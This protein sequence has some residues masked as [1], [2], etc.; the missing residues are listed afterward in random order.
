MHACIGYMPSELQLPISHLKKYQLSRHII[1]SG[2]SHWLN[3]SL[4][5]FTIWIYIFEDCKDAL[6][7]E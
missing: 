5:D 2:Q 1:R 6:M 7:E 3:Q 4:K